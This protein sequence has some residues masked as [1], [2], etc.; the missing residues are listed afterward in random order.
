ASGKAPALIKAPGE[1]DR[2]GD[3]H[4][5]LV[6]PHAGDGTP[7]RAAGLEFAGGPRHDTR[8]YRSTSTRRSAMRSRW[9]AI[10]IAAAAGLLTGLAAPAAQADET[11]NSPYIASLIKGQEDFVHV[12]TLGVEG[13]GD[14]SDK[15]VT[16]GAN[17]ASA[18]YGKVVD[19]VS[20]GGR[21]EAHHM[22]FTDD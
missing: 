3:D 7:N 14:G 20:V 19:S 2:R 18:N 6:D 12:W 9:S 1:C 10:S 8:A 11:C 5:W 15:L 16:I 17:P 21:S 22:G 4:Q 13:L